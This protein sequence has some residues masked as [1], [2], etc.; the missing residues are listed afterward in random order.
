[1]EGATHK[2]VVDCI[3]KGDDKLTL[4]VISVGYSEVDKLDSDSSSGTE[5]FD[6]SDKHMVPISIPE[7]R[8][9]QNGGETYMVCDNLGGQILFSKCSALSEVHV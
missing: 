6:Y 5:Y 9:I 1:M 4:V 3:K 7:T 2:Y 8:Q